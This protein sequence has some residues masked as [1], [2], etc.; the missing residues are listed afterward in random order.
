MA[1]PLR[2][3][4]QPVHDPARLVPRGYVLSMGDIL[5][6]LAVVA[7][8]DLASLEVIIRHVWSRYEQPAPP[9][10]HRVK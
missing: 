3:Y 9:A 4:R 7:P 8:C 5:Q 1:R 10:L 6:R 2:R